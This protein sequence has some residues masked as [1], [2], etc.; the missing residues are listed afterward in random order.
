MICIKFFSFR[1]I[2][3]GFEKTVVILYF[4]VIVPLGITG[5]D[6]SLMG[7]GESFLKREKYLCCFISGKGNHS[8]TGNGESE[9]RS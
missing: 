3:S 1:P 2:D 5:I 8:Q 6:H 7:R 9:G 4:F